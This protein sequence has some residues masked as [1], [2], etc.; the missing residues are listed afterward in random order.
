MFISLPLDHHRRSAA[1][2]LINIAA[3]FAWRQMEGILT[4]SPGAWSP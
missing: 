4:V 2:L 3:L 1:N